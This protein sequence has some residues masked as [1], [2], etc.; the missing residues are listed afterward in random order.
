MSIDN[1][2]EAVTGR[3]YCGAIRI[4]AEQHPISVAYCHCTDCRRVTGGPVAVFAEF[5]NAAVSFEPN[6]GNSVSVNPGVTRTF[7]AQCGSALAGRFAYL[8]GRVYIAIGV[9]DNASDFAPQVHAY[10][11]KRIKWLHIDDQLER[12]EASARDWFG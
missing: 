6:E 10:D 1:S 11:G 12:Y 3:C 9:L 8:Q 5:D 7:C 4:T 2:Q